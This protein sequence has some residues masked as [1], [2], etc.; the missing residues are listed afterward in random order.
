MSSVNAAREGDIATV[1][2]LDGIY[3]SST[4]I[5]KSKRIK[6]E[7]G[8]IFLAGTD[9]FGEEIFT[10]KI[11][12]YEINGDFITIK[13]TVALGGGKPNKPMRYLLA[14]ITLPA[15]YADDVDNNNRYNG[16]NIITVYENVR[17]KVIVGSFYTTKDTK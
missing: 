17:I 4:L 6:L 8:Q 9:E 3:N 15:K 1:N 12:E 7:L 13:P 14:E 11:G 10:E 5:N 16:N 2:Q